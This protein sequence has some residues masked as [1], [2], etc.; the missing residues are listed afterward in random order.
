[1]IW[2]TDAGDYFFYLVRLKWAF[3]WVI[4]V[5]GFNLAFLRFTS[6][7]RVL[8]C[9]R[10]MTPWLCISAITV[11]VVMKNAREDWLLTL[12]GSED[13]GSAEQAYYAYAKIAQPDKL[14]SKIKTKKEDDNVRYYLCRML[15]EALRNA[16]VQGDDVIHAMTNAPVLVPRFIAKNH[17]NEDM[18]KFP[19]PIKA[20]T[21]IL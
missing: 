3:A 8:R 5:G 10:G 17:L 21:I 2:S 12:L 11:M 16:P 6:G 9:F 19:A 18:A 14:I 15:G 13:D 7:R 20:R 1:M 4:L